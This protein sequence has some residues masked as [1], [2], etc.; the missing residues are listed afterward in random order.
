VYSRFSSIFEYIQAQLKTEN[1]ASAI[2]AGNVKLSQQASILKNFEA[3]KYPV[4]LL[5]LKAFGSGLNL[6]KAD[7]VIFLEPWWNPQVQKQAE[8]RVYR[9]GQTKD[10]HIY[11]F[12]ASGTIEQSRVTRH[13]SIKK[14]LMNFFIDQ[15]EWEDHALPSD[16]IDTNVAAISADS[17]AKTERVK[18]DDS[19]AAVPVDERPDEKTAVTAAVTNQGESDSTANLVSDI[20]TIEQFTQLIHPGRIPPKSEDDAGE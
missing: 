13:Q 10:V 8:D 16:D 18:P 4:L 6:Q 7:T 14:N 11:H 15:G 9:L 2:L 17:E 20:K 1:I 19:T 5:N 3:N 12:I